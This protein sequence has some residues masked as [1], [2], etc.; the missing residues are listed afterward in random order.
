MRIGKRKTEAFS[1]I[2]M[3][4]IIFMKRHFWNYAAVFPLCPGVI[5][6]I[7]RFPLKIVFVYGQVLKH[8]LYHFDPQDLSSISNLPSDYSEKLELLEQTVIHY[9]QGD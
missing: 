2:Y 4:K 8:L 9:F 1:I 7:R 6:E 5:R 3:K